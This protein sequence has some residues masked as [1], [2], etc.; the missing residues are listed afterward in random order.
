MCSLN[1]YHEA[2][3]FILQNITNPHFF[4]FSDDPAWVEKNLVMD[5][6]ITIMNQNGVIRDYEDLYLM[7]LCQHFIIANSSFSWW[8]AWLSTNVNKIVVAPKKWFATEADPLDLI[9]ENWQRI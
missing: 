5:Y 4:I 1:Y 2:I 6:P 8:A 3:K 9:P 7:S